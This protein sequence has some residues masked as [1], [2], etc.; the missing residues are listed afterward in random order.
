MRYTIELCTNPPLTDHERRNW[1][2]FLRDLATCLARRE[3]ESLPSD[4]RNQR[5][6]FR[7]GGADV[8]RT[9]K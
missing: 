4:R 8:W 9:N 5:L 7:G 2:E 6:V 1:I 3:D